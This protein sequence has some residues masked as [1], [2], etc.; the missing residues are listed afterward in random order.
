M[1][2]RRIKLAIGALLH[3]F[4][5]LLY[6]YND[7][8]NHSISGHDY[9]RDELKIKEQEILEQVRYHHEELL[10]EAKEAND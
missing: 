1:D 2:E 4:G 3:D 8:R 6:R 5:K 10:K 9:L 7:R